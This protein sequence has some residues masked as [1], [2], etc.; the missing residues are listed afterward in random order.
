M[1]PLI[2][3]LLLALAPACAHAGEFT[4]GDRAAIAGLLHDQEL[5]WNRGDLEGF[6]RGYDR[7]PDIIFTS[8]A[9][10]R[11]GFDETRAKYQARYLAGEQEM[12]TLHFEI[13]GVQEL[14]RDGAVVLG[15][16]RLQHAT[17]PGEGVFTLALL[18]TREGWRIVHDHTSAAPSAAAAAPP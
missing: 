1:R 8:G 16:W 3:A 2:R 9:E 13:L 17:R 10:V 14:G 4:K 7:S 12:G 18:R 15:R 11:R 6:L 5:A